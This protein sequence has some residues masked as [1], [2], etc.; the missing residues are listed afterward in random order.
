M[1]RNSDARLGPHNPAVSSTSRM[2]SRREGPRENGGPVSLCGEPQSEGWRRSAA[3]CASSF[4]PVSGV[5]CERHSSS[6]ASPSFRGTQGDG[7]KNAEERGQDREAVPG[8]DRGTEQGEQHRRERRVEPE[9]N[10][11][12]E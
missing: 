7:D 3:V 2:L 10:K 8:G 11:E 12:A 6:S 9:A 1:T 5:C 4:S